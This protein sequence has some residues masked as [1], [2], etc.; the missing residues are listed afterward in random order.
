VRGD[1]GDIENGFRGTP[2]DTGRFGR[3]ADAGDQLRA[4]SDAV[5]EAFRANPEQAARELGGLEGEVGAQALA[6][7]NI[8]MRGPS[9]HAGLPAPDWLRRLLLE[10]RG[11][12]GPFGRRAE[13]AL[14]ELALERTATRTSLLPD[15]CPDPDN[16]AF[17]SPPGRTERPRFRGLCPTGAAGLEPTTPGFGDRCSAS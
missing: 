9:L 5:D 1:E 8:L 11:A 12:I 17:L 6:D 16:R 15:R 13:E 10:E 7:L 3:V 2:R 14:P 4:T